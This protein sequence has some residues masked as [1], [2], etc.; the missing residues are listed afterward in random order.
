VDDSELSN[1]IDASTV[2]VMPSRYESFG[3]VAVEAMMHGRPV[4]ASD[5]GGLAEVVTDGETGLLVPVDDADALARAI[6]RLIVDA[7]LA[8]GLA[9]R[10]R[11]HFVDKLTAVAA[12]AR[13]EDVL[14]RALA[15][16]ADRSGATTL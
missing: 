4:V 10:G 3:L 13:L 16:S 14:D 11:H 9:Q 1:L 7:D 6:T 2:V 8:A 12:A 5:I 15:R